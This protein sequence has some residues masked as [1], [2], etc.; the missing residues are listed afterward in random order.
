MMDDVYYWPFFKWRTL[1][2]INYLL[3][4][5][6]CHRTS[7]IQEK[8]IMR[9]LALITEIEFAKTHKNEIKWR[10]NLDLYSKI[11][12]KPMPKNPTKKWKNKYTRGYKYDK[13][14][15]KRKRI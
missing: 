12:Q 4:G 1:L 10:E 15:R 8:H 7:M 11:Y 6:G 2:P 5:R 14:K 9:A 13:Q 3:I